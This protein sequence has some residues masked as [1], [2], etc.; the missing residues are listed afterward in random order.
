MISISDPIKQEENVWTRTR[1]EH[2]IT[3]VYTHTQTL[4]HVQQKAFHALETL[5]LFQLEE[6][7]QQVVVFHIQDIASH[8]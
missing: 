5:Q 2:F 3:D 6:L 8:L 1:D 7:Q 4:L